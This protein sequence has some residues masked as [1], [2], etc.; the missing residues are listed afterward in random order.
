M[1]ANKRTCSPAMGA[2]SYMP[3]DT[4]HLPPAIFRT[5]CRLD[6]ATTERL[7]LPEKGAAD[8]GL[9][10]AVRKQ[11][12]QTR[13]ENGGAVGEFFWVHPMKKL[14]TVFLAQA[15]PMTARSIAIFAPPSMVPTIRDRRATK[16]QRIS[17]LLGAQRNLLSF[18]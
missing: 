1:T 16:E 15:M 11:P 8:F 14:T 17:T 3:P 5:G 7:R 10:F 4:F 13:T 18:P 2:G 9:D 12:P 6:P